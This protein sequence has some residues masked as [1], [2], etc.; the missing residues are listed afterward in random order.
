M[1]KVKQFD[2]VH[3]Q[4]YDHN[5]F[6]FNVWRSLNEF[7]DPAPMLVDSVG[8]VVSE[9]PEVLAIAAHAAFETN[10]FTGEM[11]IVKNAIKKIKILSRNK[12]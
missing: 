7:D 5:S 4:W 2:L 8:Y 6:S 3:V 11:M 9:T 12:S 1:K 10:N